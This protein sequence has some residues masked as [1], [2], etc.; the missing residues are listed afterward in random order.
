MI[1]V[2]EWVQTVGVTLNA[3]KCRL[4]K[5]S[6]KV[7]GHWID[8]H[9]VRADTEKTAAICQMTPP[10]SVSDMRR[11]IGMVNQRGKFSP[12][13]AEISK[14]LCELLSI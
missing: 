2:L 6:L 8:K 13:I 11:F 9:G 7:L 5:P 4:N 3:E 14:P 12:N 1:K 10:H